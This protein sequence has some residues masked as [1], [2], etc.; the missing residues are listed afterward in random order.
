VRRVAVVIGGSRGIGRDVAMQLGENGYI[1][2]VGSRNLA[3]CEAVAATIGGDSAAFV[4]D[5][6]DH[7]SVSTMIGQ[8]ESR[9]GRIDA[10][11]ANAGKILGVGALDSISPADF[12]AAVALNM[13][14]AFNAISAVVPA[15]KRAGGGSLV[16]NS[17]RSGLRGVA[18]IGAYSAAKAGAIM[19]AQVAAAEAGAAGVRVN[20]VA[21]G[22]IATDAWMAKLGDQHDAL[23]ATV[24]LGTIG[25]SR[26]V[27]D[28]VC[29]LMS[30]RSAYVTGAVVPVDGG[31][32]AT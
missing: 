23:A 1:V 21:P 15:L 18:G 16:I 29:W 25:T 4:V 31:T 32:T 24:P 27:A 22:Y 8:V 9:Y 11:F 2:A 26:D 17:A 6:A 13:G 30:D 12:A 19:L 28:V 3:A 5:A 10:A 14:G 20:V 7:A